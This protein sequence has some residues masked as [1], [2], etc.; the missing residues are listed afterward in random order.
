MIR[1]TRSFDGSGPNDSF[2]VKDPKKIRFWL[3]LASTTNRIEV[4]EL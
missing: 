3:K 4:K 1:V 2:L